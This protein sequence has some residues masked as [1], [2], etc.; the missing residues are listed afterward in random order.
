MRGSP[1]TTYD[2]VAGVFAATFTAKTYT[3]TDVFPN[4]L[5]AA[6]GSPDT[7]GASVSVSGTNGTSS[8]YPHTIGLNNSPNTGSQSPSYTMINDSVDATYQMVGSRLD[9][10]SVSFAADAACTVDF[11]FKCDQPYALAASVSGTS[12]STQHLIPAWNCAASI[13]GVQ[14]YVVENF[15]CDIKRNTTQIYALGSQS[16]VSNFQGPIDVTGKFSLIVQAGEPYWADALVRDQQQMLFNLVDPFTGLGILFQ[17]STVQLT[18]PVID[19]SKNFVS[20]ECNFVAIANTTDTV[21]FGYS[22]I[23]TISTVASATPF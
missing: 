4:L 16:A 7:V 3:Y 14:S 22:P 11:A 17:M 13:G 2:N 5:R 8:G 9:T 6:L 20:L 19:Q 10:L 12:E 23:K 1:V 21:T 18:D 15:T